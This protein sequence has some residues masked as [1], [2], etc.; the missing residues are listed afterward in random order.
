MYWDT[1]ALTPLFVTEATTP[2]MRH[3]LQ[4]DSVVHT[5]WGTRVECVSAIARREREGYFPGEGGAHV[6]RILND[7]YL[8]VQEMQPTEDV[9]LRA[10]RCLS[11]HPLRAADA[12]QLA[13]AL[14]WARD[15]P[16]GTAFVS[17]DDRLR[18]A[19][20]REGFTVLP[21]TP[22]EGTPSTS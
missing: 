21:P 20:R 14:I 6:R 8:T 1:S 15:R 4:D 3:L 7:L 11:L 10:E 22:S 16:A 9:R 17:L 2:V 18:L 13:A 12:L 19:A 5:G